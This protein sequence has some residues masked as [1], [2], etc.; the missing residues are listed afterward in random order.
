[1][2]TP[3]ADI[4]AL[5]WL[6]VQDPLLTTLP[7]SDSDYTDLIEK[8]RDKHGAVDGL[9]GNAVRH[10]LRSLF[11]THGSEQKYVGSSFAI[12]EIMA[13]VAG[14]IPQDS[15][16]A[17][18]SETSASDSR[19]GARTKG[20]KRGLVSPAVAPSEP[21]AAPVNNWPFAPGIA[22]MKEVPGR[23]KALALSLSAYYWP[24]PE[25]AAPAP[26]VVDV[27]LPLGRSSSE[28]ERAVAER[29]LEIIMEFLHEQHVA[30]EADRYK[31]P[32]PLPVTEDD[33]LAYCRTRL[34]SSLMARL[35]QILA[36]GS[37]LARSFNCVWSGR[38]SIVLRV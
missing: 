19:T 30:K 36:R 5:T 27:K 25:A 2:W 10:R 7:K 11:E 31:L 37:T 17:A 32:Q 15:G 26:L 1:V 22:F 29:A 4:A 8:L 13:A 23:M 18:S 21:S 35:V 34:D 28:E 38:P 6:L 9:T 20:L 3:E 12:I 24:P 33:I 16:S 14:T